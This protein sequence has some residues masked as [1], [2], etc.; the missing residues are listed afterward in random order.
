MKS[1]QHNDEQV[2]KGA[3]EGLMMVVHRLTPLQA[4]HRSFTAVA[5]A[6]IKEGMSKESINRP[7]LLTASDTG[8]EISFGEMPDLALAWQRKMDI[9]FAKAA[10]ETAQRL[11]EGLA[12]L[13][14]PSS[15]MPASVLQIA[16]RDEDEERQLLLESGHINTGGD[17]SS[18]DDSDDRDEDKSYEPLTGIEHLFDEMDGSRPL[19]PRAPF[20]RDP[21]GSTH[22]LAEQMAQN[23]AVGAVAFWQRDLVKCIEVLLPYKVIY[24]WL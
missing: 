16:A 8:V 24:M 1:M 10:Q 5:V 2:F 20:V 23:V 3:H 22:G 14:L 18:S 17:S 6:D 7:D 9:S 4:V 19:A 15:C 21:L 12:P 11:R 13:Q